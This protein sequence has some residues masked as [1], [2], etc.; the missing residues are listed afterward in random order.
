MHAFEALKLSTGMCGI[1]CEKKIE[2]LHGKPNKNVCAPQLGNASVLSVCCH[3]LNEEHFVNFLGPLKAL[4]KLGSDIADLAMCCALRLSLGE[5][6]FLFVLIC[7]G[8]YLF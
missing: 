2:M 5:H 4:C 3:C 6:V 1:C 8:K 7:I